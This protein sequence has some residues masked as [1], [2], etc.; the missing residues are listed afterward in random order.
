MQSLRW[1]GLSTVF[2]ESAQGSPFMSFLSTHFIFASISSKVTVPSSCD[3]ITSLIAASS[4]SPSTFAW[5]ICSYSIAHI[6][7][8]FYLL[9]QISHLYLGF[10]LLAQ[11]AH[12]CLD[13]FFIVF[14]NVFVVASY[15]WCSSIRFQSNMSNQGAW[16]RKLLGLRR[17]L[18]LE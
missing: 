13:Y 1:T 2:A 11:I 18:G 7:L 4:S 14:I 10:Y 8:D 9:A 5:S 15:P 3:M 16:G 12:L 17:F 6:R